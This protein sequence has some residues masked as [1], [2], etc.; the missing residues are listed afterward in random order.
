MLIA[1]LITF[2]EGLEA[3]L[4]VGILIGYL[5]R[6][7]EQRQVRYAWLGI[8]AA[9]L[10]SVA[11]A[12]A[13]QIIGANLAEPY[14]QIFEGTMMLIAVLILTWM[15]FWMHYQGRFI[16]HTLERQVSK[17]LITGTTFGIFGLAF[18]AVLREGI[19]TALFLSASAFAT[20]ALS[21]FIGSLIGLTLAII[22]G[23]ALYIM[24]LRLNL[25]L[26]F[27]VTSVF[28]LIFAAGLFAQAM[29]EFQ[30]IGWLPILTQPTWNLQAVLSNGSFL[31]AILHGLVGYDAAPTALQLAAYL[32]YWGAVLLGIRWWTQHLSTRMTAGTAST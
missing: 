26:M 28:L 3:A 8:V 23:Y 7:G 27:S 22:A 19:E 10:L 2:R 12:V 30:E 15:I 17:T 16:K 14:E 11:I 21:T 20:D 18:V 6:I 31:G 29:H 9:G 32:F 25:K 13:L 1:G 5:A 4:I 24:S